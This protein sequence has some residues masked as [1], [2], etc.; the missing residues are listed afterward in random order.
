LY[1]TK[2]NELVRPF[3]TLSD[4]QETW[5]VKPT[6]IFVNSDPV[7]VTVNVEEFIDKNSFIILDN[8]IKS[9]I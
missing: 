3:R 8:M 1:S 2:A 9:V 7:A 4:L 5:G 6:I